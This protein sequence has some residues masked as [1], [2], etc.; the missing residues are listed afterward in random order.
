MSRCFSALIALLICVALAP[1]A[2]A[3]T[4]TPG[5][6]VGGLR[7]VNLTATAVGGLTI[8]C[9]TSTITGT[10]PAAG[11]SITTASTNVTF[12]NCTAT[13]LGTSCAV[14][15]AAGGGNWTLT[16][17]AM[18]LNPPMNT[19]WP[20][21]MG[22]GTPPGAGAITVP[23]AACRPGCSATI[24][25]QTATNTLGTPISWTNATMPT[26][27]FTVLLQYTTAGCGGIN[28]GVTVTADYNLTTTP[29]I[30][31]T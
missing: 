29:D 2:S 14:N 3:S 18:S 6:T 1:P 4:F 28:G 30:N 20:M 10:T 25:A 15:I 21:S 19:S 11:A 8:D 23:L 9:T 17:G 24:A 27:G 22:F 16:A 7:S 26:F 12:G 31:V 13:F 5:T